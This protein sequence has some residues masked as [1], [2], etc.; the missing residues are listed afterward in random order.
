VTTETNRD[1]PISIAQLEALREHYAPLFSDPTR[2][3]ESWEALKKWCRERNLPVT[4]PGA[5]RW[6]ERDLERDQVLAFRFA[7][8]ADPLAEA[9]ASTYEAS[10]ATIEHAIARGDLHDF[11]D[12]LLSPERHA[13][14]CPRCKLGEK[15]RRIADEIAKNRGRKPFPGLGEL[16]KVFEDKQQ[17]CADCGAWEDAPAPETCSQPGWHLPDIWLALHPDQT[18]E[19]MG[20]LGPFMR[21]FL[22]RQRAPEEVPDVD[23]R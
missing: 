12:P 22:R 20:S 15:S 9:H 8:P 6:F 7:A 2:L 19:D 10:A 1:A 18:L 3:A 16:L 5:M 21:S 11:R 23:E 13:A 14:I 4:E 17:R